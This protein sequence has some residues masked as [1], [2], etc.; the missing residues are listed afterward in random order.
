[1]TIEITQAVWIEEHAPLSFDE[2][3]QLSG[4]PPEVVHGLI[5]SGAIEAAGGTRSQKRFDARCVTALLAARRLHADFELDSNGVAV[6][7]TLLEKIR[8]LEVQLQRLR[9][10][11]PRR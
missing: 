2:I 4:L 7:V 9:T 1:M 5:D 10:Q 6:A 8:E 3:V 11:L